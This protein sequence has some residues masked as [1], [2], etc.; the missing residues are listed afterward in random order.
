MCWWRSILSSR[1]FASCLSFPNKP[2]PTRLTHP[3]PTKFGGPS[4]LQ[5]VCSTRSPSQFLTWTEKSAKV[6]VW[7]SLLPRNRSFSGC[8][9]LFYYYAASCWTLAGF[10]KWRIWLWIP[11]GALPQGQL[12]HQGTVGDPT[13]RRRFGSTIVLVKEYAAKK[14]KFL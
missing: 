3:K 14:L 10:G 8:L 7:R 4:S 1:R 2:E 9:V 5:D 13:S 6:L 12:Q 11:I